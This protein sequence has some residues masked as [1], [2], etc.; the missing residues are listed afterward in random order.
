MGDGRI[1]IGKALSTPGHL[2]EGVMASLAAGASTLELTAR[3]LL[4]ETDVLAHGTT[5]GLNA[6]I[7][8]TGARVGLL[9]TEGFESTLAIAK[10]NK[11]HGL[12]EEQLDR[13]TT[14]D[15]PPL[16]VPRRRTRGI[17]GRIDAGG[18][19]IE[20]L[21][22][23]S[24]RSAVS[25]L[26]DHQ[27][28]SIAVA[29]LWSIANPSH[30]ERVAEIIRESIPG[31]FVSISSR[32]APRIGEYE[33]TSTCVTDAYIAPLLVNY[34]ERVEERL[35]AEGFHG[36]FAIL[37]M[38][39][40]V[41]PARVARSRPVETLHSGPVGGVSG[42]CVMG[43][44]L[45]HHNIITT[46]VGGTSF[47]VGLV[48]GGEV[49]YSHKPMIERQALAIPVVD[50][51][52]IGTG[53]GS[54]ARFD[55]RLGVLRVGPQSAGASPGP[56]CYGQGGHRATLTDAAVILGYVERLGDSM[57]LSRE[58]AEAALVADVA[59]PLGLNVQEAA[60]GVVAV[61]C[62]QMHDLVRRATIQRGYDP[63]D[64]V[65]YG[66]GGA[67]PQY[68]YRFSQ[69]LGVQDVVVP[70]L[71]AAFS[72]FGA[73]GSTITVSLERDV[74]SDSLEADSVR[75]ESALEDLVSRAHEQLSTGVDKS[76]SGLGSIVTTRLVGLRFYRQLQRID[77]E[78]PDAPF[79][80][81][82]VPQLVDAFYDRY[83]R[84]VGPGSANDNTPIELV[85]IQARVSL[86]IQPSM[87]EYPHTSRPEPISRRDVWFDGE[88]ISTPI[89][90]W[91][92]IGPDHALGGPAL[93][94]SRETT[95]VIG[96]TMR[97]HTDLY[98]NVHFENI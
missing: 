78:L 3:E 25:Y 45:G 76:F 1:G 53:G 72:A 42:A 71:A 54:I 63:T 60:E 88:K 38:G 65:L 23:L 69:G 74:Q 30:E 8:Q 46:D 24:V 87:R 48:V 83:E 68:I 29:L 19:E 10:S 73:A 4:E 28:E 37:R 62:E 34:F 18:Q 2:E 95:I 49:L 21:D 92:H 59:R 77:I 50:V 67:G 43:G 41:L 15:K 52:S 97:I 35:F 36:L 96:T 27:C 26:R 7:T 39:G 47:D 81:A 16:L 61:A 82:L 6:M 90:D 13:A 66:F 14:W 84:L 55:P 58:A 94:E 51:A 44:V 20:P 75:I 5:T 22:E 98:T 64:F 70:R 12:T 86:P 40:G 80:A 79:T 57:T 32:L 33:R 11:I 31:A 89:F 56:A 17:K 9:T 85:S 93:I 91:D